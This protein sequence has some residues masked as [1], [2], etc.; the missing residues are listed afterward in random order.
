M[1]LRKR[2]FG[3]WGMCVLSGCAV[4]GVGNPGEPTN[5]KA[6]PPE[7]GF[8]PIDPNDKYMKPGP[9]LATSD[10]TELDKRFEY[11]QKVID[12]HGLSYTIKK[13][14]PTHLE[15]PSLAGFVQPP[16]LAGVE[17]RRVGERREL[18][19]VADLVGEPAADARDRALIAQDAVQA[20]GV[21]LQ[22]RAERRFVDR[23][24][25]GAEPQDGLA[26][27]GIA[28]HDP[29]AGSFLGAG[30][31]EQQ[32]RAL[33][34]LPSGDAAPRLRRLLLVGLQPPSLHQ[35][36]DEGQRLELEQ[37]VLAAPT[38]VLERVAERLVGRWDGRLER[39]E[40]QRLEAAQA[41][42]GVGLRQPFGVRL[43]FGKL[44][45]GRPSGSPS[46]GAPR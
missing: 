11:H 44:G 13:S 38:D 14:D 1:T 25:I 46:G 18:R 45:H 22:D 10:A 19:P 9:P 12:A 16:D 3:L 42:A 39:R 23:V 28:G 33:V 8:P 2:W 36:D 24:G 30:L 35:V 40:A 41:S 6:T 15:L 26:V 4:D 43:D 7:S 20:P 37:E 17:L 5:E 32:G 31:G 29:H 21:L 27:V 34:E